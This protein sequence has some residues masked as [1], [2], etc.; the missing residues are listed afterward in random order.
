MTNWK[1]YG[2]MWSKHYFKYCPVV[3]SFPLKDW[4]K[5]W[6][7][8]KVSRPRF[9]TGT[10]K[11]QRSANHSSM[12]GSECP[13]NTATHITQAKLP[14]SSSGYK[15]YIFKT[16]PMSSLLEAICCVPDTSNSFDNLQDLQTVHHCYTCP[17]VSCCL[18]LKLLP[19]KNTDDT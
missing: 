5:P 16:V 7:G 15:D 9:E 1:E 10:S 17:L 18:L 11:T 13:G 4:G 14:C 6:L 3:L 12:T 2:R 19:N 8:H